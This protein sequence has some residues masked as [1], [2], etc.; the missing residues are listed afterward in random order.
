[1]VT[2]WFEL[3]N[4]DFVHCVSGVCVRE[5]ERERERGWV[6]GREIERGKTRVKF[7]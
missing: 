7:V 1:M 4:K 3:N 6:K 2:R 5:R